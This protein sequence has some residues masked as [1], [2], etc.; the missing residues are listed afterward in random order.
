MCGILVIGSASR[1]DDQV[2][3]PGK[4]TVFALVQISFGRYETIDHPLQLGINSRID[5]ALYLLVTANL[6]EGK[7]KISVKVMSS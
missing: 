4:S 1:I 3:M 7:F 5:W 2:Q 6:G